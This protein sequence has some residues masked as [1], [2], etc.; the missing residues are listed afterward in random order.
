MG[1]CL[2][3]PLTNVRKVES[4]QRT[5]YWVDAPKAATNRQLL[6]RENQGDRF[7]VPVTD[8][9][10]E[11]IIVF[12]QIYHPQ[13]YA[14]VRTAAGWE[15]AATVVVNEA[16]QGV[17]VPVG[18]QE[19]VMEFRPWIYWGIIPNM[20]WLGCGVFIVGRWLWRYEPL[21]SWVRHMRKGMA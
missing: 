12:S 2:Q 20:F 21:N 13:W 8:S 17:R 18:T 16:Y 3:V 15:E 7:V 19:V 4:D 14:R 5:D 6:Q 10:T 9:T 11:S 1:C